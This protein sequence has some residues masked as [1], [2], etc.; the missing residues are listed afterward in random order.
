MQKRF[1]V[2]SVTLPLNRWSKLPPH[3]LNE[4]TTKGGPLEAR[5]AALGGATGQAIHEGKGEQSAPGIRGVEG[6]CQRWGG[7][8]LLQRFDGKMGRWLNESNAK[9]RLRSRR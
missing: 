9:I 8:H 6:A 7:T 5:I 2:K 3:L 1:L 4:L